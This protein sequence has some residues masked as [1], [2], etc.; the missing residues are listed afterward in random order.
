MALSLY[1]IFE[2]SSESKLNGGKDFIFTGKEQLIKLSQSPEWVY[3]QQYNE[4]A[5]QI[6]DDYI[7]IEDTIVI[8]TPVYEKKGLLHGLIKKTI[9]Q[10]HQKINAHLIEEDVEAYQIHT[11]LYC[12]NLGDVMSHL[13]SSAFELNKSVLDNKIISMYDS[14]KLKNKKI[15]YCK[16][17][18]VG[19]F[20][21]CKSTELPSASNETK[22]SSNKIYKH[23]PTKQ[24]I[25]DAINLCQY[26]YDT[27][28]PLDSSVIESISYTLSKEHPAEDE[29]EQR[30]NNLQTINLQNGW[31]LV[32]D[33]E[34]R[35]IG[36]Q[37]RLQNKTSGFYSKL[38][39]KNDVDRGCKVYMYCTAGTQIT[40][41][42]DWLNNFSQGITGLS[43][44]YT[45]SVQNALLLDQ[46]IGKQNVLIFAGHSLGGGLASNNTIVTEG[47]YGITFNAAGLNPVRLSVTGKQ[48]PMKLLA[49][50]QYGN[51]SKIN[52][53]KAK[54]YIYAFVIEGEIL[55]ASLSKVKQSALGKVDTIK[56]DKNLKSVE[57]H[58]LLQFIENKEVEEQI[59]TAY[60]N[61][62]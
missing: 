6:P 52:L 44:Q 22:N 40:S 14:I 48:A 41:L 11:Y 10:C 38:F 59:N 34:L 62:G 12:I 5:T 16:V 20:D 39:V 7:C 26:T 46:K 24:E 54:N 43:A 21:K 36:L 30:R 33:E 25:F 42:Q 60:E 56:L 51:Q 17:D 53:E 35:T 2:T 57:K 9:K 27:Q 18:Y 49:L 13:F 37:G 23:R 61:R 28:T 15:K 4:N 31:N 32:S 1:I 55:N 3:Q 45:F 50:W 19:F 47:R 29:K 8:N 58:A